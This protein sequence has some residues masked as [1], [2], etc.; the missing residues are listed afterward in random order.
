MHFRTFLRRTVGH[1]YAYKLCP[2]VLRLQTMS[3]CPTPANPVLLSY[4]GQSYAYEG[5]PTVLRTKVLRLQTLS[6]CPTPTNH[7]LLSYVGQA[8]AYEACPT[9][10]RRVSIMFF[11]LRP[12]SYHSALRLLCPM[13]YLQSYT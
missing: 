4:V 2:T 7:V 3:Y 10:L 9:V 8:Y 13:R 12:T 5:C 11:I 1:S 6:Y